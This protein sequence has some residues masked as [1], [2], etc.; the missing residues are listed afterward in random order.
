MKKT[1]LSIL[2]V[3]S[4]IVTGIL[5]Y[6]KINTYSII[7]I[8]VSATILIYLINSF[9]EEETPESIYNNILRTLI[10]TYDSILVDITQIPE[11]DVKTVI[12]VSSF[13]KLLD[14]QYELKKPIFYKMSINSCSFLLLDNEIAYVFVL[15]VSEDS[16][17][18]LDDIIAE[19]ERDTKQRKKAKKILDS[20]EHTTIIKLDDQRKYKVSP[21]REKDIRKVKENDIFNQLAEDL[22]PKLK[23]K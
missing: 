10:K 12:N 19:V 15:R 5:F 23:K 6:L 8:T 1:I 4:V 2:F 3:L 22:M 20:I 11:L 16:F 7:A 17:S 18:P 21:I 9:F 13:E 14:V